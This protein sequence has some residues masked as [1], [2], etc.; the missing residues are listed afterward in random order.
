MARHLQ[1]G[2]RRLPTKD[3]LEQQVALVNGLIEAIS[4]SSAGSGS[5]AEEVISKPSVL[6]GVFPATPTFRMPTRPHTPLDQSALLINAPR[7]PKLASELLAELESADSVSLLCAFLVW[8]GVRVLAPGL[9]R[10]VD[11]GGELK[12]IT[13]TYMGA[14]E[15]RALEYLKGL[16]ADI[17]VS[18]ETRATRLHA[19]AWL[20]ERATGF[21]TAYIGSSNISYSALH[22]GL[23]WNVRI[24]QRSDPVLMDRFRA[25]FD[26]YW[27]E[28]RFE[29]YE[30]GRFVKAQTQATSSKADFTAFDVRPFPY[31]EEML[32]QLQ[33][34]R[35]RHDRWKNLVVA[36]TGTGKTVVAALDYRRVAAE[37]DGASL[38]FV[39][40]RKEILDQ[41]LSTFRHVMKDGAFGEKLVAGSRPADWKHVFGSIQSMS[42]EMLEQLDPH[43]FDVLIIDEFHHAAAPSYERLLNHFEPKLLLGLTATPERAD[44]RNVVDWFDGHIAVELRLWEAVDQGLLCPFQYFGIADEVDVS[45]VRWTRGGYDLG[46]LSNLYTGNDARVA[47]VLSSIGEVVADPERMRALGFCVGVDHA[48]YMA[49]SFNRAGIPALFVSGEMDVND[50]DDALRKLRSGEASI[51][52]AVDLYNEGVD[53]PEIDTVLFLRPTESV[54]VFLQQLGRGLRKAA[55]KAGLTVLDFV[56]MQRSEFRFDLRYRALTGVTRSQLV[57]QIEAGFPFLPS[58]CHIHLDPVARSVVIDNVRQALSTRRAGLVAELQQLGD[59]SLRVF[60]RETGLELSDIYRGGRSWTALRTDAGLPVKAVRDDG[61]DLL[62]GVSRLLHLDDA[63]RL[64]LYTRTLSA[65]S[66]VALEN[67]SERDRRLMTMLY[68]SL[69]NATHAD[70]QAAFNHVFSNPGVVDELLEVF[71]VLDEQAS[72]LTYPTAIDPVVPLRT[73]ARYSRDEVL[74]AVGQSTISTRT[75]LREGVRWDEAHGLDLFFVTLDKAERDFSPTTMYR[76]FPISPSLFHWESQSTTSETSETGRRYIEHESRGSK[77]LLF[78]RKEK[79]APTGAAPYLCLGTAR[80]VSHEGDRPMAITWKL[81]REMP[82]YFFERTRAAS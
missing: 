64:R 28:K 59:V 65:G 27:E 34:E 23:E 11:R 4:E 13:T 80:Y 58:G 45:Q 44:G 20:F 3:R 66:E 41:S 60:L 53:V 25:A 74:A 57:D 43:A 48:R 2:L 12:V 21:S 14:T 69:A 9:Q 55:G 78:V 63:E 49:E 71:G 18:Y 56:G 39:A 24:S 42:A 7:E 82:P 76:D 79:R 52:F 32:Y 75:S 10:L 51:V 19:K 40:H 54:T 81:D 33:V 47:K 62:R 15:V 72:E 31:Q 68:S 5:I 37:L 35:E 1:A 17:K 26:S 46:Q 30:K 77:V 73:H 16:G 29:P 36:A 38:L 6:R 50:R 70:L 22:E 8:T 61:A 67:L